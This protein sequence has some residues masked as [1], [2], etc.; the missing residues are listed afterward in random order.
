MFHMLTP[1]GVITWALRSGFKDIRK[2]LWNPFYLALN[3]RPAS[4]IRIFNF[5]L[6]KMFN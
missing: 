3:L 6:K 4:K 5:N 2:W 1:V